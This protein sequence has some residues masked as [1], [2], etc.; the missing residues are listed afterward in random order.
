MT[1]IPGVPPPNSA[2][3]RQLRAF[4]CTNLLYVWIVF[5]WSLTLY[6]LGIDF[7]YLAE[8]YRMGEAAGRVFEMLMR[9]FGD[10]IA[11]YRLFNILL[12]YLGMVCILLLT[13][14]T[15]NGPWWLGSF[16]AVLTMA[17]PAKSEAILQLSSVADLLP[18][19]SA[20]MALTAF[21]AWRR[22]GGTALY[23]VALLLTAF[24]VFYFPEN[25][26]L[27]LVLFLFYIVIP[28]GSLATSLQLLPIAALAVLGGYNIAGLYGHFGLDLVQRFA[29]LYLAF[30]PLGLRAETATLYEAAPWLWLFPA[31]LVFALV[32][33]S[34]RLSRQPAI[35]FG[36]LGAL[37]FRLVP[38]GDFDF[39]HLRGGGALVVPI[40]LLNVAAAGLWLQVQ[41]HPRW[42]RAAVLLTTL[43]CVVWM[44]LQLQAVWHWREAAAVVKSFQAR[45]SMSIEASKGEPVAI[46]P[47]F[48]Y[49]QTAPV[50]CYASILHDTHFS[51]ELPATTV[52][53]M[54][55]FRPGKGEVNVIE[56][57][58]LGAVFE[59]TGSTTQELFGSALHDLKP[60][61]SV[62]YELYQMSLLEETEGVVRVRIYPFGDFLPD[63]IVPLRN[64]GAGIALGIKEDTP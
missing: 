8:P 25:G 62:T 18:A 26:A 11:F 37:A 49:H 58:P 2:S 42:R 9:V 60:G 5:G 38:M 44:A 14:F 45:A 34:Y 30:Y 54:H 17:N 46:A 32:W 53:A 1:S 43:L 27:P 57:G 33:L 50:A 10:Q 28:T 55:Y 23:A 29:P 64:R 47:D 19:C 56:Y 4:L 7:A 36:V 15:L 13:R 39:V 48:R 41:R 35:L 24:A 61:T 20:L 16:A 12:L 6:P 40:A 52:L 22:L 21:A 3:R 63:S 51:R 59:I 31:M